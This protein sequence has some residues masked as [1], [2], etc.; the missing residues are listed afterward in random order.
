MKKLIIL[1]CFILSYFVSEAQ[2][3]TYKAVATE[4]YVWDKVQ[5]V[6]DLNTKNS[7]TS[8]FVVVEK[9]FITFQAK[10]P[11]MYRI[12]V[13]TKKPLDTKSMTGYRYDAKDLKNNILVKVDVLREIDGAL[14]LVSIINDLEGFNLRFFLVSTD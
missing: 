4:L 5:K 8:I 7:N 13:D 14:V 11:S 1:L 12:Y 2:E 9:D 6:W 3:T 10:S